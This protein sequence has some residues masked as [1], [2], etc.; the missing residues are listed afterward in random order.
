MPQRSTSRSFCGNARR[1]ADPRSRLLGVRGR[2]PTSGFRVPSL[3]PETVV[4]HMD[5]RIARALASSV[6]MAYVVPLAITLPLSWVTRNPELRA[7]ATTTIPIPGAVAAMGLAMA[8]AALSHLLPP[9]FPRRTWPFALAVGAA[10]GIV[11]GLCLQ[12]LALLHVL[13]ASSLLF[14]L[15]G[16]LMAGVATAAGWARQRAR[17]RAASGHGALNAAS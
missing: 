10:T 7:A 5:S 11:G 2:E 1:R 16:P 4:I 14:A 17:R 3:S 12:L 9:D 8:L 15:P 13:S 6:V